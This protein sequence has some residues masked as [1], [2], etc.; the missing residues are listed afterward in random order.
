M[1]PQFRVDGIPVAQPRQRQRVAQIGGRMTSMNYTPSKHPV[2]E[3]KAAVRRAAAEAIPC[4]FDGPVELVLVFVLP[5]PKSLCWKSRPMPRVW[6]PKK[7]DADNL[8]KSV[9]DA[10]AACWRDD[11]QVCR[12]QVVKQIAAGDE[13][14]HVIVMIGEIGTLPATW[15]DFQKDEAF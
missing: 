8:A 10:M 1:M 5:R 11:S 2:N 15:A 6:C 7:P 4:P 9:L 12:L 3:F 14:P 13:Q